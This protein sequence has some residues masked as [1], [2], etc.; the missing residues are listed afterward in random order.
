MV[1]D[2]VTVGFDI[3]EGFLISWLVKIQPTATPWA[4][5]C[6]VLK[7]QLPLALRLSAGDNWQYR[8]ASLLTRMEKKVCKKKWQWE[9]FL[10]PFSFTFSLLREWKRQHT[11]KMAVWDPLVIKLGKKRVCSYSSI[12]LCHNYIVALY[13]GFS[14]LSLTWLAFVQALE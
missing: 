4:S 6:L 14:A 8:L 5:S 1:F 3:F 13:F 11:R 10:P 2:F 12:W 7:C 9:I